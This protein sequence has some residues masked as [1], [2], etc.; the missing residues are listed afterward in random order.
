MIL[1]EWHDG[2]E[3]ICWYGEKIVALMVVI[4]RG[5]KG[6]SKYV[7]PAVFRYV[8][9]LLGEPFQKTRNGIRNYLLEGSTNETETADRLLASA[10]KGDL[11]RVQWVYWDQK[12]QMLLPLEFTRETGD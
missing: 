9:D 7:A 10:W 3:L 4:P 11:P 8:S 12:T 1:E 5:T 6:Y 2:D